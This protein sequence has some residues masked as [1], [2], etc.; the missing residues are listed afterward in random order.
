MIIVRRCAHL[1]LALLAA[2]IANR[3]SPGALLVHADFAAR[4]L[5][6]GALQFM[7][8]IRS[9]WPR[10]HRRI[11]TVYVIACLIGGSAGF[12]LALS[13]FRSPGIS[14][15]PYGGLISRFG[16]PY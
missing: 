1:V 13:R 7:R 5:L 9:R 14:V 4:A 16:V 3:Y 8:T 11:G 6:L 15:T 12:V 2:V 10:W